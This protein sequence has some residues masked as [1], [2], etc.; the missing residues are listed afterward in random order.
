M[1]ADRSW[2]NWNQKNSGKK[3]LHW[4]N[5]SFY[6]NVCKFPC[7][8]AKTYP[9]TQ[10][11]NGS[12]SCVK[13]STGWFLFFARKQLWILDCDGLIWFI[14]INGV[15]RATKTNRFAV[16]RI[17]WCR[18]IQNLTVGLATA[19]R[20]DRNLPN[21]RRGRLGNSHFVFCH[22]CS[23]ESWS[24][25]SRFA[26]SK[27]FSHHVQRPFVKRQPTPPT[28]RRHSCRHAGRGARSVR[29]QVGATAA[30]RDHTSRLA[31]CPRVVGDI[32]RFCQA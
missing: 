31:F 12:N 24:R 30:L 13:H 23:T 25:W 8:R 5:R 19:A 17:A 16:A 20:N 11:K 28:W 10:E 1:L 4:P 2:E 32:L 7:L 14:F 18:W 29:P 15:F 27:L 3:H 6:K 26:R 9:Q 22:Y 21:S